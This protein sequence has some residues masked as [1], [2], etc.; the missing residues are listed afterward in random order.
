[1]Y[2]GAVSIGPSLPFSSAMGAFPGGLTVLSTLLC[3]HV[4]VFP[5]PLSFILYKSFVTL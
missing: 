2:E 4:T 1:M 3:A 5:T